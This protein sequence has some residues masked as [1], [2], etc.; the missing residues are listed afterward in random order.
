MLAQI[1]LIENV[2]LTGPVQPAGISTVVAID[3]RVEYCKPQVAF[4]FDGG[5]LARMN[6][7]DA[8]V[9]AEGVDL[10]AARPYPVKHGLWT[11]SGV[12]REVRP[13]LLIRSDLVLTLILTMQ[14]G[15][16]PIKIG[17]WESIDGDDYDFSSSS[18]GG[19]ES[20]GFVLDKK[21]ELIAVTVRENNRVSLKDT[22]GFLKFNFESN[23]NPNPKP[24]TP[25][26]L[27]A[28][29]NIIGLLNITL[30]PEK[31]DYT[32]LFQ[33]FDPNSVASSPGCHVP[34]ALLLDG[35]LTYHFRSPVEAGD[36]W[37]SGTGV[38]TL[39]QEPQP[40]RLTRTMPRSIRDKLSPPSE[41]V[42]P[43]DTGGIHT[44]IF[45][46]TSYDGGGA[47]QPLLWFHGGPMTVMG[48]D[49]NPLLNYIAN[50]GY[51]VCVPNFRG[52][53]GF[54]VDYMD[55]VLGDGCGD[56]DLTDCFTVGAWLV[57]QEPQS[58][59]VNLDLRRGIGVAGHSWGGYLA[60]M[61]AV[62]PRAAPVNWPGP[63]QLFSCSVAC[64]GITDWFIQ[65]RETEV[66]YY[67][68]ALMGGW[69]YKDQ[70]AMRARKASPKTYASKLEVPLL[71]LHGEVMSFSQIIV[72]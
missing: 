13:G 48:F 45:R 7:I 53:T 12:S 22:I 21:R 9:F 57:E 15:W 10:S 20:D 11:W 50:L 1:I 29:F 30:D 66:R 36:L 67:D 35:S 33:R 56:A 28:N 40:S 26:E 6:K 32:T 49:Y 24:H 59:G 25:P 71:V 61:C 19:A 54:G 70:V 52:S 51:L 46:P 2:S 39:T 34:I 16:T 60:F 38:N 63:Q 42:V 65:Q 17:P 37:N 55:E 64:A 8:V 72:P 43:S 47:I 3:G 4:L 5:L 41:V 44:L 68:Y 31:G 18:Y 62:T 58:L 69:V 23:L 14:E 27:N